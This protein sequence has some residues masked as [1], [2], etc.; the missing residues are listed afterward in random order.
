MYA[1]IVAVCGQARQTPHITARGTNH[2]IRLRQTTRSGRHSPTSTS[3]C[4]AKNRLTHTSQ[5]NGS[6]SSA[7]AVTSGGTTN[8]PATAKAM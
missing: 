2:R 7:D 5:T 4:R 3:A 8:H 1:S 6:L